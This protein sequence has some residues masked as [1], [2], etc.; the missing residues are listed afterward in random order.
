MP[1]EKEFQLPSA[2]FSHLHQEAFD[3]RLPHMIYVLGRADLQIEMLHVKPW[4]MPLTK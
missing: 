1:A 3:P 2:N 4:Q